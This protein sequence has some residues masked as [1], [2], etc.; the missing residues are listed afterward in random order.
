MQVAVLTNGSSHGAEILRALSERNIP[1]AA[2]MVERSNRSRR[3]Q[4]YRSIC[5]YGYVQTAYDVFEFLRAKV[6]GKRSAPIPYHN[7]SDCVHPVVDFNGSDCLELLT[8]LSPDIIVLAGAPIL[9]ARVLSTAKMAVLNAHPGLLPTYRGV[10]VIA[11]AVLNGDPI[12]VTLH[13][14]DPGIDT[15]AIVLQE[16]ICRDAGDD[17]VSLQ[18]KAE[19][20]AGR[21]MARAVSGAL[22]EG[23]VNA[24]PHTKAPSPLW[25]R[26]PR[27]M[28]RKAEK[29]MRL[30]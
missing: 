13:K 26:M 25:R 10:D 19:V 3:A 22:A 16:C 5:K 7:Y 1:I 4:L 30:K 12:G 9:K 24:M 8:E 21:L 27:A 18:R 23:C 20:L 6:A 29:R 2:I 28:I 11:W 14:V 17:L 15:G